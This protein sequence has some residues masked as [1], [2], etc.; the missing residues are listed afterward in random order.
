MISNIE[1]VNQFTAKADDE[2]MLTIQF[3]M[4]AISWQLDIPM[5]DWLKVRSDYLGQQ[6]LLKEKFITMIEGV[7][8]NA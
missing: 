3:T 7:E 2:V 5:N 1:I 8:I 4:F 6:L